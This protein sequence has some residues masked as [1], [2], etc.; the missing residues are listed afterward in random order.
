M[1]GKFITVEGTEGVGKTTNIQFI[2]QWLRDNDLP[3]VA[4]REPGGT[5]LAEEIREMLLSP[6]E[7][8]VA[9]T[10]EL[11]M[12]FASR[13]QH[14]DRVIEPTLASGQ[15]LLCDR[16]TDA[17]YAY[18]GGG[19]GMDR[20]MILQLEKLVQQSLTPDL[21]LILDLPIEEGLK[22]A[23]DRSAPDRF[24]S[25][26]LAFFEN[27]RAAYLERASNDP[28][29]CKVIDASGTIE[30]VQAQIAEELSA[31]YGAVQEGSL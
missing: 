24:E 19:R 15:W 16:F 21:T 25:E 28:Q 31:F 11:L 27:V 8:S 7:E 1:R 17:T 22:R 29:R 2:Q 14:I 13:A 20:Q 18:Q 12:M 4:T 5:P 23:R 10:A 26:K 6:R 3:F 30:M 9:E